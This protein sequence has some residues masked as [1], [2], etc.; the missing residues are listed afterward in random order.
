MA[1]VE[2]QYFLSLVQF[3]RD[4]EVTVAHTQNTLVLG[5]VRVPYEKQFFVAE[6]EKPISTTMGIRPSTS[7]LVRSLRVEPAADSQEALAVAGAMFERWNNGQFVNMNIGIKF[8]P[9]ARIG[10]PQF[11]PFGGA[12]PLTRVEEARAAQDHAQ[13]HESGFRIPIPAIIEAFRDKLV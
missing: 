11:K 13:A 8:D 9:K 7:F 12:P 3:P 1:D 10:Q 4:Q 6:L 2:R 5:V